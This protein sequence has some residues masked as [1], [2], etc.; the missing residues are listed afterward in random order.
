MLWDVDI[1]HQ[2]SEKAIVQHRVKD[3]GLFGD[4]KMFAK[5]GGLMLSNELFESGVWSL[6]GLE[7]MFPNDPQVVAFVAEVLF[8]GDGV[9]F[10]LF[11]QLV[12]IFLAVGTAVKITPLIFVHGPCVGVVTVH[13]IGAYANFADVITCMEYMDAFRFHEII[14]PMEHVF[15][16]ESRVWLEVRSTSSDIPSTWHGFVDA[17]EVERIRIESDD[18]DA[19][20]RGIILYKSASHLDISGEYDA[21]TPDDILLDGVVEIVVLRLYQTKVGFGVMC[22]L[23]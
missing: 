11:T 20:T 18:I 23:E 9:H 5:E 17:V 15:T 10:P 16:R 1:D 19:G 4:P 13:K 8:F 3:G 2:K 22:G 21:W 14:H 7:F 12:L 6:H